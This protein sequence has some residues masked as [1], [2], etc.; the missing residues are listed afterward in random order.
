MGETRKIRKRLISL[1]LTAVVLTL[2]WPAVAAAGRLDLSLPPAPASRSAR[3]V[4][5]ERAIELSLA[6]NLQTLLAAERRK[7]A[8]ARADAA[9][10]DLLPHL[11]LTAS[12][13]R[14]TKN[15]RA[16]G[17]DFPGAP[18][19]VGPFNS[20]DARVRLAQTLFDLNAY[21]GLQGAQAGE[22]V[23]EWQAR[24]AREQVAAA[25]ARVYVENLRA[26]QAVKS[27][28]SNL[29]LA[30]SLLQLA[31]DQHHSGVATGVDVARATTGVARNRQAVIAARARFHQAR[32]ALKRMLGL[33]QG[34]PLI[35]S[36]ELDYS[37]PKVP[38]VAQALD[39]AFAHRVEIK[40]AAATV[41]QRVYQREAAGASTLPSVELVAD[42]GPSG[43]TPAIA[44]RATYA[45]GVQV[46][47]PIYSG[48]AKRAAK[49][50]AASR[51]RQARLRLADIK[52]QIEEDVRLALIQLNAAAA[53]VRA[54]QQTLKLAQREFNLARDRF[55]HGL[56]DT[57]G[58]VDADT[59]LADARNENID[60]LA[61]Y[62]AARI[63][64]AA[65]LG[66]AQTFHL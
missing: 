1:T 34:R 19:F 17:L 60:A 45:V 25:T 44:T 5:L 33:P 40:A 26:K 57:I 18:S 38:S 14:Q 15:L 51:E 42:Y 37:P 59:A 7:E 16:M 53:Q 10:A 50:A 32:L 47:M 12:Q 4:S 3:A 22:A 31:R 52:R 30:E 8:G 35:L 58:V 46:S 66:R 9:R 41:D 54:A 36:G 61:A 13:F 62:D 55:K 2:G 56:T 23:A 20:F 65:A 29:K 6:N 11:S 63:K 28:E 49:H 64:L 27:A 39:Y 21:R 24:L 43:V 48:G